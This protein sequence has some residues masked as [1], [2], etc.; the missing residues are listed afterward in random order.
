MEVELGMKLIVNGVN[1]FDQVSLRYCV[2]EMFA[3]KRSDTL[4]VRF[5]DPTGVWSKWNP[6]QGAEVSF[7]NGA[8]RTGKMFLY[9][10]KPENGCFT[11]RAMSMPQSGLIRRSKSWAGVHFLQIANEIAGRNSLEFENYGCA[12]QLYNYL[13]QSNES[14]FSF[15]YRL[16]MLEGCQMLVF[17]GKLVAYNE[18]YIEGQPPAATLEIGDDGVFSYEDRTQFAYGA[19]TVASGSF[20]GTYKAPS[21][22]SDRVLKPETGIKVTSNAEALRFARGLLRNANKGLACGSLTRE[23]MLGYAAASV[24]RLKTTKAEAWNGTIFVTGVR[25]DHLKNQSTIFFR[26]P[27]EGY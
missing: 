23:L 5:N 17:D 2:H 13:A 9:S 11:V 7:E 24:I 26:K 6:A 10:T 21:G 22:G 18:A 15:F 16:C 27:L 1:I 14:D 20:S 19:A 8:S 3:E 4:T 12:D 25:H